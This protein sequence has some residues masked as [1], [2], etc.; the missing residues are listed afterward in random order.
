MP[1]IFGREA[2]NYRHMQA[3]HSRDPSIL[4]GFLEQRAHALQGKRH[5]FA[6]LDGQRFAHA[7]AQPIGYMTDNLQA[8]LSVVEEVLYTDFRL[9]G[10]IPIFTTVPEGAKTYSYR[11]LD[12]VGRGRFIDNDGSNAPSAN[13]SLSLVPYTLE[14]AGIVPEWTVEDVRA[15][16]FGGVALDAETIVAATTGAM[17]HI[18]TVGLMGD[19]EHGLKGLVN[20]RTTGAN[21]VARA[22][23]A[24]TIDSMTGDEIVEFLQK[25]VTTLITS[26]AEVFGRTIRTGLCIYLPLE[27]GAIVNNKRLTDI[28]KTT[29]EYFAEHNLWF[30]YTGQRPML[31]L[32][33][34]LKGAGQ[35]T[36]KN[37]MIVGLMH[38]RVMEMAMPISPRLLGLY[39]RGYTICAPMEYKISGL[40]LKRPAGVRYIDG[41]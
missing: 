38:E 41:I 10:F 13:T 40:N 7:E 32:V 17:D 3:M 34:E 37:R 29:W 27:Q 28:E 16:M 39:D 5:D 1:D 12:R 8:I 2:L 21:S 11:V 15:A 20:Q 30:T 26:S 9:D 6:A 19:A 31:K 18:E 22:D 33:A 35:G 36:D 23:A 4:E 25:E 24:A 14:Y